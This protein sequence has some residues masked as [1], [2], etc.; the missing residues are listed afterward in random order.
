MFYVSLSDFCFGL[1]GLK[2]FVI[3]LV[4]IGKEN[5]KVKIYEWILK[6]KLKKNFYYV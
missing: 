3:T 1:K 5:D 2:K 6:R 4:N